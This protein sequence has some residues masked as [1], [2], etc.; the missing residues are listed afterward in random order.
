MLPGQLH[1]LRHVEAAAAGLT[2]LDLGL[3]AEAV[4]DDDV[5]ECGLADLRQH[6]ELADL[7]R[8][9]VVLGFEPPRAGQAAA[10]ALGLL[11]LDAHPLQ[12]LE[13]GLDPA[14]RLVVAVPPHE[15][16]PA[17][18]RHVD[19]ELLEELGEVVR[20]LREAL[21]VVVVRQ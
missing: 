14:G 3:A 9:V 21:R 7:H 19:R 12:Q 5:V 20:L 13:L 2:L 18:L 17:Q 6:A 11:D 1:H 16:L 8:Q 15:R 10:A 4:G